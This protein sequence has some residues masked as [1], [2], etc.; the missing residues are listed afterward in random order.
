MPHDLSSNSAKLDL[1]ELD[2]A[3]RHGLGMTRRQVEKTLS[4]HQLACLN[5]TS[6]EMMYSAERLRD[7]AE[8]LYIISYSLHYVDE[9]CKRDNITFVKGTKH[10]S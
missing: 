5:S 3:L 7:A 6:N 8:S 1:V 9:A 10:D 2:W 4:D